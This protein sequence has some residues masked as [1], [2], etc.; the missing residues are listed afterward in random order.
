M[1]TKNLI[2]AAT[3]GLTALVP[4][5]VDMTPAYAQGLTSGAIQ[6]TVTDSK[7]GEKLPGVTVIATSASLAQAQTAITDENGQYKISD[8]PPAI[9]SSRSTSRTSR[10]SAPASSSA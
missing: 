1:K 6:G 5:L 9:T 3:L 8:L 10:S 7:T 4:S 2:I